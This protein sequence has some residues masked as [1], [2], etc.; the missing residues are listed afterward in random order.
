M[1]KQR[2]Q[3]MIIN[4]KDL[5]DR[6]EDLSTNEDPRTISE[7]EEFLELKELMNEINSYETLYDEDSF[8]DFL[9]ENNEVP[10]HL[11]SYIN[12]KKM[13]SDARQDFPN[14]EYDGKI[15]IVV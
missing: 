13:V 4:A 2:K 11:V 10:A 3:K 1:G 14:I 8:M 9:Q 15:W 5:F 6:F 12:W 7:Q